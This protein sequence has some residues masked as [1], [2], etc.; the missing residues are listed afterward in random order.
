MLLV[1]RLWQELGVEGLIDDL[2]R[3]SPVEAPVGE[4]LL[5][6]VTNRVVE[7]RSKRGRGELPNTIAGNTSEQGSLHGASFHICGIL[8][9]Y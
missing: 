5:A 2:Y 3:R 4:A 9:G 7:P 8:T 1:R 6:M